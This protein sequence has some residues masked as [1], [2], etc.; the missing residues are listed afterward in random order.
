[1]FLFGLFLTIPSTSLVFSKSS[2]DLIQARNPW[3]VH[4]IPC[5]DDGAT[6]H[7]SEV[8]MTCLLKLAPDCEVAMTFFLQL[9]ALAPVF[10]VAMTCVLPLAALAPVLAVA[11]TLFPQL[12]AMA[13]ESGLNFSNDLL[14]PCS[15]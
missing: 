15:A 2:L 1:M 5:G 14:D 10:E 11:L 3:A 4:L 12:T 6:T 7:D 9:A 13:H 8:A